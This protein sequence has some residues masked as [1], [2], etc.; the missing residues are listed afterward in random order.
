MQRDNM[1]RDKRQT[2]DADGY[3]TTMTQETLTRE[4]MTQ[5]R[6]RRM[7]EENIVARNGK[8]DGWQWPTRQ[9]E[10]KRK[11]DTGEHDGKGSDSDDRDS[12]YNRSWQWRWI[13]DTRDKSYAND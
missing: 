4:T 9:K 13:S 5:H 2:R 8:A 6:T 7:W 3:D 10:K 12:P 1:T 11:W